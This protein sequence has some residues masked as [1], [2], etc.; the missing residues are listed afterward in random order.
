MS[1]LE[2]Q[3]VK[4]FFQTCVNGN[5]KTKIK[6]LTQNVLLSLLLIRGFSNSVP[7]YLR[8]FCKFYS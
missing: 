2:Y 4:V 5:L 6:N 8:L 1:S 3:M 7:F